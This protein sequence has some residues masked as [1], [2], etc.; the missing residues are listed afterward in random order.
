V[1]LFTALDIADGPGAWASLGFDVSSGCAWVDDVAHH[2]GAAG[3]GVVAW[4]LTGVEVAGDELDGIPT[5]VVTPGPRERHPHPNGVTG[6]DHVVVM[7][8][9]HRRTVDAFTG[10]GLEARRTRDLGKRAQ[11]FFRLGP[12]ILELVGPKAPGGEGPAAIFGLAWTC[13]DLAETAA[14]LGDR[15]HRAKPAV[16]AGRTIATL[17]KGAGSTVA[18]AFMSPE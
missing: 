12:V 17:D 13:A 16:Q 18:M 8:P 9:D 3:S 11:T 1:A 5:R 2:L 10:A 6:L 7:S 4:E 14:H 15:L